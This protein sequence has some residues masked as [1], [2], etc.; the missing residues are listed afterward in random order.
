[1]SGV[2]LSEVELSL[3]VEKGGGREFGAKCS[4]AGGGG[5]G[6]QDRPMTPQDGLKTGQDD[7]FYV[8]S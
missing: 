5:R 4:E 1:M 3:S 6:D 7:L 2:K 8:K